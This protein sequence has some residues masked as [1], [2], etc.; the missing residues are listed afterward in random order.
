MTSSISTQSSGGEA[1]KLSSIFER[2]QER[3]KEA[4]VTAL[5]DELEPG[6]TAA[7][8]NEVVDQFLHG[9]YKARYIFVDDW[10][11]CESLDDL[12]EGVVLAEP[13]K[14]PMTHKV[15]ARKD[16]P[17]YDV[18][19]DPATLPGMLVE[20]LRTHVREN[21]TKSIFEN[22]MFQ[23]KYDQNAG[24]QLFGEFVTQFLTDN[25]ALVVRAEREVMISN[26]VSSM[27]NNMRNTSR[28]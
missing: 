7:L 27:L 15:K 1:A 8:I 4:A 24:V 13:F 20:I 16:N 21:Y 6:Q 5:M 11:H 18:L 28:Y 17:A 26:V 19:K 23:A 9:S 3:M 12:P 10:I 25:M 22:P 2:V 14:G